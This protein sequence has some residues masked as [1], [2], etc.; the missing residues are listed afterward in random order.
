[1]S[2]IAD[3][4]QRNSAL[5]GMPTVWLD[6]VSLV[7]HPAKVI[8]IE[9]L[10]WMERPLS[11][12]ELVALLDD[13]RFYLSLVSYHFRNLCELGVLEPVKQV[14]RRGAVETYYSFVR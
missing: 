5:N 3:N 8:I 10:I 7:I 13:E 11:S 1:M 12:S 9:A 2:A 4:D 14:E 6:L